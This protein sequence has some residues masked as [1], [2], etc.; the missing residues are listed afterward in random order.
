M[1]LLP[2]PSNKRSTYTIYNAL[3][4][5]APA[6]GIAPAVAYAAATAAGI[7]IANAAA[8]ADLATATRAEAR[9]YVISSAATAHAAASSI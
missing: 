5:V 1:L 7:A 8:A 3:S 2:I 9:K 6:A 4:A